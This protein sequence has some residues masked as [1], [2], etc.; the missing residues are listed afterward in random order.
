MT[1]ITSLILLALGYALGRLPVAHYL[2]TAYDRV[3]RLLVAMATDL[4]TTTQSNLGLQE[5][6]A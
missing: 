3:A 6:A 2:R 4:P 5:V 1:L